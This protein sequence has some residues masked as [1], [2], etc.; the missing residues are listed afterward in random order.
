MNNR[1]D[2]SHPA[3]QTVKGIACQQILQQDASV[4]S[5]QWM[6]FSKGHAQSIG[7]PQ[8]LERY[9]KLARAFTFSVVR[10]VAGPEG[11][12]FR[13]FDSSFALLKFA[14]PK[15]VS[16]PR[17]EEVH[18]HIRG[19]L[20]V[21]ARERD[22]GRLSFMVERG[23]AGVRI[24]LQLADYFPLLLGSRKPSRLRT[25]FFRHTQAYMHRAV[26]IKF[27]SCLHKELT[28]ERIR[29]LVDK[30]WVREGEEI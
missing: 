26:A 29:P 27:L 13:L 30:V 14:P 3:R 10:P 15:Q 17:R 28:G 5:V 18:L 22:C 23:D 9:L 19:G 1:P 2:S 21:Q 20:L 4:Y 8:L 25:L 12:Q 6:D 24:T 7:A 16:G 11:V